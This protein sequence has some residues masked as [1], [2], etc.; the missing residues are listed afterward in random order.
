M[1]II[2]LEED[3]K[4]LVL[5]HNAFSKVQNNGKTLENFL[6]NYSKDKLAQIYLQPEE[7]DFDFCSKYFR[8]TDYE[9]LNNVLLKGQMGNEILPGE[10]NL[11]IRDLKPLVQHLYGDR[12]SKKEKKGLGKI[13]HKMFIN[14]VP[15]CVLI[16]NCIWQSSDWCTSDLKN[17]IEDFKPDVLFFQGSSCSFAYEIALWI[18]DEYKLPLVLELTDDYTYFVNR[19]SAFERLNMKK[20]LKIF[21]KAIL[22]A[23]SIIVISKYM[24]D[25]YKERFGG[26]QYAVLMN[27]IERNMAEKQ[28]VDIYNMKIVYAGNVSIGRWKVIKQIGEALDQ[29]NHMQDTKYRLFVFTPFYLERKVRHKL[30][31]CNSINYG[32]CLNPQELEKEI[33]TA[34]M[35]L[36]VES[37]K[38]KMR[39]VTR[40]S[41]STKIPEYMA[42]RRCIIGVGPRNIGSI[43]YLQ[44]N[45]LGK[46]IFNY[47]KD[48]II[49]EIM[50]LINSPQMQKIF[51]E[52]AYEQYLLEHNPIVVKAT[53]EKIIYEA[54]GKNVK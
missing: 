44:D 6:G 38:K 53:I 22:K 16:R 10:K 15:F 33:E 37:F 27:A 7:P 11:E 35:L 29:I 12:Y 13:I 26:K 34:D 18:C 1:G 39:K 45:S 47:R 8:I 46:V 28:N 23:K 52:H 32:G 50:E 42:S 24:E 54:S 43:R 40:L 5:S 14:R 4:V 17:W 36:H 3:N 48:I 20:Y 51:E 30:S 49:K 9:A 21:Q 2:K 19:F 31:K 25:E 41:I